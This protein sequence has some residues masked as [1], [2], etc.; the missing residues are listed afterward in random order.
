MMAPIRPAKIT[1]KLTIEMST[2]PAADGLGDGG[3]EGERGDEVEERRPDD[4]LPRGEDTGRHDGRDRVGGVV[5]AVDEVE[6]ERDDD[7]RDDREEIGIHPR[8]RRA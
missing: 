6:D 1:L 2:R 5:K 4:R 3:P 7:Q 8:V